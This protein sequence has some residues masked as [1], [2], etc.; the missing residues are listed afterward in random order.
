M[1]VLCSFSPGSFVCFCGLS[2]S[3]QTKNLPGK[4]PLP[5]S[6]PGACD[7][8]FRFP[9]SIHF[10]KL[11]SK[12]VAQPPSLWGPAGLLSAGTQRPGGRSRSPAGSHFGGFVPCRT[13][14]PVLRC[15]NRGLLFALM[16]LFP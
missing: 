12:G 13:E 9:V 14:K 8:K 16:E 15:A 3:E 10:L 1:D 11:F 6:E 7:T 4:N 5:V 2:G